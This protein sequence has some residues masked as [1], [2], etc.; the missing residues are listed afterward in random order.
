M[1]GPSHLTGPRYLTDLVH[2]PAG[3]GGDRPAIVGPDGELSYTA[4]I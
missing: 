1:T 3:A 2:R 4:L